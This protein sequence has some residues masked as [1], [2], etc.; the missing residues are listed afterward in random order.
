M[1]ER[2]QNRLLGACGPAYVLLTLAAVAI[3][4]VGGREFATISTT[5]AQVAHELAKPAGTLVWTAAYLEL[6]SAGFFLAFA[7]WACAKLGGGL[8][9]A[10]GR[11]A[12]TCYAAVG[13]TALAV[14]D[15]IEYR[16]GHGIGAQLG[17]VLITINEALYVGTWFLSV[18]F[19]LAVGPLAL[20]TGRRALGWSAIGIAAITLLLTAVSLD[21][22]GQMA[23]FLWLVWIVFASIALA[24]RKH[25]AAAAVTLPQHA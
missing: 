2:T 15:A 25:P 14:G 23:N 10:I 21:N 9:G 1:N 4:A 7:I 19:L 5:P 13:V 18:F 24:R 11:A 12:A 17:S 20:S 3:G 16:A 22:L 8:L 6:L